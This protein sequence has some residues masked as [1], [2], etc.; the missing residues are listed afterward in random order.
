MSPADRGMIGRLARNPES[1]MVRKAT[2]A[3]AEAR[4][5]CRDF[6]TWKPSAKSKWH[7]AVS[8]AHSEKAKKHRSECSNDLD[9]PV[10]PPFL[11]ASYVFVHAMHGR[12]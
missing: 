6:A 2:P 8:P 1:F 11:P 5:Q 12:N 9:M 10:T 3:Q 7:W 4:A